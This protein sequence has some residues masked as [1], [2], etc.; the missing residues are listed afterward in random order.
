MT[1]AVLTRFWAKVVR[2]PDGCWIWGACANRKGYGLFWA[3]QKLVMAHRYSYELVHG[4]IANGLQIDHICQTKACVNPAHL[5]PVTPGKNT[6]RW[7][8]LITR[9][10]RGHDYTPEN[11]FVNAV[12][13]RECR[14]CLRV[15]WAAANRRRRSS[16]GH[17]PNF[18]G[19]ARVRM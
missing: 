15:K 17:A 18:E 4:A 7:A 2:R 16:P 13:Y 19:R 14:R 11:T 1:P 6:R 10:P 5:E 12:G 3:D 8:A 9:C